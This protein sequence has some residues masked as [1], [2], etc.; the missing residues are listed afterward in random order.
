MIVRSNV[1]G[2]VEVPE[3]ARLYLPDGLLGFEGLKHYVLVDDPLYEP[4]RW[5]V[6]AEDPAVSFAVLDPVDAWGEDYAVTLCDSDRDLLDY[7]VD[8]PLQRFVLVSISEAGDGF[9]ADLKGPVVWNTRNRLAKQV[10][11]YN[12][13]YSFRHPCGRRRPG[14]GDRTGLRAQV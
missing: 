3:D 8:D 2:T 4:F 9:A 7:Q 5:L 13:A 14:T 1:L 10:V 12:P 11:V 6:A